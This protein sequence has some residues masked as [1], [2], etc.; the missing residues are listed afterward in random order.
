[1]GEEG[2]LYSRGARLRALTTCEGF[3]IK[4]TDFQLAVANTNARKKWLHRFQMLANETREGIIMQ[5][6]SV[7][8][9][10]EGL[11][12][13]VC[14]PEIHK[15]RGRKNRAIT[16]GRRMRTDKLDLPDLARALQGAHEVARSGMS[17]PRP[18]TTSRTLQSSVFSLGS[19]TI[20]T[21]MMSR[22]TIESSRSMSAP[23]LKRGS[24]AHMGHT[25]PRSQAYNSFGSSKNE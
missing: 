7:K 23:H 17:S 4:F 1:M 6:D 10:V 16:R 3:R 20:N 15:W 8:G 2:L 25:G 5:L 12:P 21:S 9:C 14:D 24:A 22:T 11:A 18:S 13:H 19:G